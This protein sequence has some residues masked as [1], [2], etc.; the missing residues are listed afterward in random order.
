[1]EHPE[2]QE[3]NYDTGLLPRN[4]AQLLGREDPHLREVGLLASIVYAHQRDLERARGVPR[5][6]PDGA[7]AGISPWR[8][9]GFRSALRR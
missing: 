7:G 2:F 6:G 5:S 1:M 9:A 3:G 8:L 4:H